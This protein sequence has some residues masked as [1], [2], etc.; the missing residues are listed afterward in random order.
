MRTRAFSST[1]VAGPQILPDGPAERLSRGTVGGMRDTDDDPAPTVVKV[2]GPADI[3]GVLPYRLGF[4][5]TESLVVVCLDGPR[6]R[7][8]LVMRFDLPD[9]G[10]EED[11]AVAVADS[12]AHVGAD[13]AVLVCYTEADDTAAPG[14][15]LVR[16]GLVTSAVDRLGAAGVE[17]VEALLVR[18]GRWW[19]YLC[20]D[21]RCCPPTGTALPRRPTAAATA[22]AAEAVARGDVVLPGR[23]DLERTVRPARNAVAD[24]VR[25]QA[26]E[27]AVA[28]L[29]NLCRRH[30]PAAARVRTVALVRR[31]AKGG[32]GLGPGAGL[33][34]DVAALVLLGLRDQTA[35]DEACTLLLDTDPR[36]LIPVLGALA[37]Q[38]DD[39]D[40]APVCTVLAWTAYAAGEGALA[41]VALD[42]ALTC[43]PGYRMARLLAD[44]IERLVPPDTIRAVTEQ[45]RR[46]L[47]ADSPPP[48]AAAE[49]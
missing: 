47:A 39:A 43:E 5:P 25:A 19:S 20:E 13:A 10:N 37:R 26:T 31:L 9:A 40:A 8:R 48:A 12:V 18:A 2:S 14:R 34:A 22:Y 7:D 38:A 30:G 28:D 15:D 29:A 46:D 23:D 33:D 32:G 16:R 49:G 6:R 24:A 21:P 36:A 35:R 3:L 44:G 42:R 41:N 27:R 11:D 17:V 4:H 1:A 45:V